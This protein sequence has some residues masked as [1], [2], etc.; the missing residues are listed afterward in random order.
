[1]TLIHT[2]LL[3][4]A[5]YLKEY[6]KLEKVQKNMYKNDKII[7]FACGVGKENTIKNLTYMY[8]NF[9]IKKAISI[10]VAGC[11]DKNIQI[12]EIF[13]TSEKMK[14]LNYATLTSISQMHEKFFTT[15][16]DMEAKWF[17]NCC[18]KF[19]IKGIVLK[20]VSDY[21]DVQRLDKDFVKKLIKRSLKKWVHLI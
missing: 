4:E 2:A 17:I 7:L 21:N 16:V 5:I 13:C 18:E 14:D 12:G 8:E 19:G 11:R 9:E 10:G 3:C 20:V 1:M 6:F 15:L